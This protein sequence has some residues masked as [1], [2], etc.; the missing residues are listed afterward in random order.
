LEEMPQTRRSI[1]LAVYLYSIVTHRELAGG[2][3][4][5]RPG[6]SK[7]RRKKTEDGEKEKEAEKQRTCLLSADLRGIKPPRFAVGLPSHSHHR[8]PAIKPPTIQTTYS[9]QLNLPN[10][11]SKMQFSQLIVLLTASLATTALA[12]VSPFHSPTQ[13]EKHH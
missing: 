2:R 4:F 11:S 6:L 7:Q 13:P 10:S 5:S 12:A 8:S 3:S 9:N 1:Q